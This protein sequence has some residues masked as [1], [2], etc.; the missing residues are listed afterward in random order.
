RP[1]PPGGEGTWN[2]ANFLPV[3]SPPHSPVA[4]QW[5]YRVR[6]AVLALGLWAP[7]AAQAQDP[8]VEN[9]VEIPMRDGV[10]LRATVLHP[11]TGGRFPTLI[12]RTPYGK[13]RAV[14][15]YSLFHHAVERG[16]A[17]VAGDV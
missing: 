4:M 6:L 17:V 11:S 12:Y 7:Q 8:V 10:V 16:Y 15:T 9:S 1:A 14:E 3:P 2:S 13:D 5:R